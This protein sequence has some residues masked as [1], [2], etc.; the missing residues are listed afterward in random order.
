MRIINIKSMKK[1]EIYLWKWRMRPHS[2]YV[3]KFKTLGEEKGTHHKTLEEYWSYQANLR[4]KNLNNMNFHSENESISVT[5]Y[6][7]VI[8]SRYDLF[9]LRKDELEI[10]QAKITLMK[11]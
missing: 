1:G 2:Y 8:E 10:I 4:G 7:G 11:L 9:K 3:G 5:M 6:H